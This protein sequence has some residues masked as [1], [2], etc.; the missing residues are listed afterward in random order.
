MDINLGLVSGRLAVAPLVE[1]QSDGSVLA[2]M[3]VLVRSEHWGRIDVV[4]V[5][6]IDPPAELLTR[7]IGS[8]TGVY[9]AG[10]L[11]RRGFVDL[12]STST[13]LDL[14]AHSLKLWETTDDQDQMSV[15]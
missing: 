4:P 7:D 6:M 2:R 13:R 9:F 1:P 3:L 10:G 15:G 11:M 12:L 14:V 5:T 8:G